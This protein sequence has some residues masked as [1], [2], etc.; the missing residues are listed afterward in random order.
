MENK[1]LGIIKGV[2][3]NRLW[4]D[5]FPEVFITVFSIKVVNRPQSTSQLKSKVG[6]PAYLK[7]LI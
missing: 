4:K 3:K 1:T 7:A 6:L 2:I 5:E